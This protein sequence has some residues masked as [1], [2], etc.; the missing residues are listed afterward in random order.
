MRQK[1]NPRAS[2]AGLNSTPTIKILCT[3]G[4]A[5]LDDAVMKQ[6]ED[7]KVSVFRINMSHTSVEELDTLIPRIQKVTN[8]PICIDT[9]GAQ[10]RTG[11]F[12][13]G[14]A[15]LKRGDTVNLRREVVDGDATAFTLRPPEVFETLESGTLLSLDFNSALLLVLETHDDHALA[16]VLCGGEVGNNKGVGSDHPVIL[17]PL[18]ERDRQAIEVAQSHGIDLFALSFVRNEQSVLDFRKLVGPDSTIISKVETMEALSQLDGIIA[19]SDA[20]LIDRGDLSRDVAVEDLPYVQKRII[21]KAHQKP[22]PTY[23]ATNLLESMVSLPR[24]MRAEVSDIGSTLLDGANGL[25][26]AAETAIGRYPV[27]CVA[28]VRRLIDR[29]LEMNWQHVDPSGV[30]NGSVAANSAGSHHSTMNQKAHSLSSGPDKRP[31]LKVD[32]AVVRDAEQIAKGT[33]WPLTGFLGRDDIDCVLDDYSLCDGD[34]WT[35]PIVLQAVS[36]ELN[37]GIGAEVVL[38]CTCCDQDVSS[39]KVTDIYRFDFDETARRWF[40]STD[41]S[42]P[43]V[44]RLAQRG[45]CFVGGEVKLLKPHDQAQQEY[46]LSPA[47][48][49]TIIANNAWDRVVGFHTRNTPHRAH[50]YVMLE[51]MRRVGADAILIHPGLGQKRSGDFSQEA[52]L[53]GYEALIDTDFPSERALLSGFFGNS[54]YAGPREAVFTALCRRNCGCSHFVVGRDHTGVG[55][56]YQPHEAE[57][58]FDRLGNIGIEPVFF[59]EV[60]F[61]P[62]ENLY[63][64]VSPTADKSAV[65][66]ISG[67]A[68]RDLIVNG[69]TPPEWMMRPEVSRA[70]L[71]IRSE[72]RQ[73][74]VP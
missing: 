28:M 60:V 7:L 29:Y 1:P 20:I 36:R 73:V 53:E 2:D 39:V 48:V 71:A 9:E 6:M 68:I 43:G 17:P 19:A 8:V 11:F 38:V 25:V 70:L 57:A 49:R 67:T 44:A 5:S 63:R 42:H 10:I 27:R 33:Y 55:N 32:P 15:A 62:K 64:E 16:R 69:E 18:T 37:F 31:R 23:V 41:P 34:V 30:L 35:L 14:S 52:I 45:D 3:L 56:F 24:P 54:W 12:N 21:A 13:D 26:L 46:S 58:L 65:K 61:D 59:D 50:E 40:G 74:V 66:S 22:I 72:G 47:Q 4:P 51:A